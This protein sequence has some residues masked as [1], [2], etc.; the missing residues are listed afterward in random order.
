MIGWEYPPSITGGLGMA[1]R[2]LAR[3][4]AARGHEVYFVLPRVH[5]DEPRDP[6]VHLIGLNTR[7][8]PVSDGEL[9]DML[10]HFVERHGAEIRGLVPFGAYESQ[11]PTAE[12]IAQNLE[13]IRMQL[14]KNMEDSQN[15]AEQILSGGYGSDLYHQIHLYADFV[16]ILAKRLKVDLIHAHDWMTFPAGLGA[17][18]QSGR[19]L[20]AHVHATEFDRSGIHGNR[21]VEDLERHT[22]HR[23]N[24]VVTV[25][26]YTRQIIINRYQVSPDRVFPVH[27][28]VE[29]EE[30][31]GPAR[32]P[33]EEKMVTFLGRITFQKGPDYFVRAARKVID[34]N[35]NVRFVM[36]G[37]G[38]MYSRMIEMAADLGIGK[39]FHYTG[40]LKREQIRQIYG[41]SDL[42]VIP[43]VSEPFGLTALEAM[44]QGVP[45]VVSKQSGV[46]EVINNC[47][48][49]DFWDIDA[50]AKSILDVIGNDELHS[51][52]RESG[53]QEARRISWSQS[54]EK[55]EEVY[56]TVLA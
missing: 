48:K 12:Q 6:G 50:I 4:V 18:V 14:A 28:A 10:S 32:R 55:L 27:N 29:I 13:R 15:A 45:V 35:H 56:R 17:L 52:M 9:Q 33:F 41:M 30:Q 2:G 40:F 39:Y 22:F 46:S 19:P 7:D 21:Y 23:A 43:S 53:M 44:A 36:V 20:V 54:A 3:E 25:S 8:L 24:A 49:V 16:S 26:N 31:A 5:G 47:I 37:T 42:Y 38:D 51:Q 1:C 11:P 34:K